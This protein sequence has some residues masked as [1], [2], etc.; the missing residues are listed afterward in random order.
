MHSTV[1]QIGLI[2]SSVVF[3]RNMGSNDRAF[4]TLKSVLFVNLVL[5]C[6]LALMLAWDLAVI[7]SLDDGL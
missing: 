7:P 2:H 1:A 5:L 6:T 4:M 3:N